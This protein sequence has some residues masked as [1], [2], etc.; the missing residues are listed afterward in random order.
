[1]PRRGAPRRPDLTDETAP[2]QGRSAAL[3]G[4][5][6][7][8]SRVSGFARDVVIAASFGLGPVMDA[9]AVALRIPNLFRNLLSEG[10]LSA[11]FVPIFSSF[12]G[13]G[14]R[15]DARRLAQGVLGRLLLLSGFVVAAGVAAA[16]W[17]VAALA[18]G[19]DPAKSELTSRLVRILFPMSGV[20]I[21]GAWCLGILTS[22]RRFFL[23]F[24]APVLWNLSQIVGLLLGA[25]QG[26]DPLIVVLAWSTLV[27]SLLQVAVQLPAVRG[28]LGTLRPRI[29]T[30]FEPTHRAMRNAGP[31]AIGQG[32]FQIS[33]ITDAILGS[34]LLDGAIAGLY[35]AQR[36]VFLPM[37]MFGVSVAVAS[38]PEMSREAGV[39]ALRPHFTAG[40]ERILYFILPSTVILLLFGDLISTILFQRGE[41][42]PEDV[43]VVRWALAAY[44]TGL[45]ATSLTKL[46]AS[47]FHALQ[48]TKAPVKYAA[49]GVVIGVV[50]GATLALWL[51]ARGFGAR[52]AAGLALGGAV[53]AWINLALL[54]SGLG[55]RGL[56]RWLHPVRIPILRMV[57]GAALAG[58]VGL[59][60][61]TVLEP[62]LPVGLLGRVLLLSALLAAG[63][64]CYLLVA[65][66]PRTARPRT[67]AGGP[68]A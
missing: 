44:A 41:F 25:R 6:I 48:D 46:F 54:V 23:P 52:A 2:A 63:G 32:I 49:V 19:F 39:A 37:A 55:R 59:A 22:H 64:L 12:L 34:L 28:V 17:L 5:G 4:A 60:I 56:G 57:L 43:R 51:D 14:E 65:G 21:A 38:L 62:A 16:P 45:I 35:F 27:G 58:G 31:V 47:G 30:G 7:F 3:V 8:T 33:S 61:R 50:M 18:P 36:V 26:W 40:V 29:D 24:A 20:M 9:Y 10:A 42:G 11:S 1:M 66:L 67:E 13:Q 68:A 53:G 15:G